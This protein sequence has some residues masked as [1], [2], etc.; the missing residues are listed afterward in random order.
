MDDSDE[1]KKK[2]RGISKNRVKWI[3]WIG[4]SLQV[5]L[6]LLLCQWWWRY[7]SCAIEFFFSDNTMWIENLFMVWSHLIAF[8]APFIY[9][10]SFHVWTYGRFSSINQFLTNGMNF[11]ELH[12][13]LLLLLCKFYLLLLL[14]LSLAE[15][16]GMTSTFLTRYAVWC[17]FAFPCVKPLIEIY[18]LFCPVN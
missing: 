13:F 14:K 3:F 5:F 7:N 9:K 16:A 10:S 4:H 18:H 8:P 1:Y 15:R 11:D 17:K 2:S 12:T 6:S